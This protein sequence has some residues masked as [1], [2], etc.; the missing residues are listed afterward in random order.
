MASS[1]GVAIQRAAGD[2]DLAPRFTCRVT[3]LAGDLGM[4]PGGLLTISLGF[5]G[6]GVTAAAAVALAGVGVTTAGAGRGCMAS[7]LW[8]LVVYSFSVSQLVLGSPGMA[9]VIK[10][11]GTGGGIKLPGVGGTLPVVCAAAAVALAAAGGALTL[12]CGADALASSSS[13]CIL[14]RCSSRMALSKGEGSRPPKFG[15][16]LGVGG[17]VALEMRRSRLEAWK[18]AIKLVGPG[19]P[20][21]SGGGGALVAGAGGP[22]FSGAPQFERL[23]MALA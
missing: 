5:A 19:G 10:F 3:V 2:G 18:A 14:L 8:Y 9:S 12:A 17:A 4:K 11:C 16:R 21:G 1:A 23:G 15:A 7:Q 6:V 20:C 13:A 22:V